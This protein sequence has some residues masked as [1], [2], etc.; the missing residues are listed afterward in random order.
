[1][2]TFKVSNMNKLK[3]FASK[4]YGKFLLLVLVFA[5]ILSSVSGI[6]FMT[7][8]YN[9]L[10]VDDKKVNINEYVNVLNYEMQMAY[11]STKNEEALK[12]IST[13]DFKIDVLNKMLAD[14]VINKNIVD[15][16]ITPN[17]DIILAK[18]VNDPI[19][20]T[21][22]R[23]DIK[24]FNNLIA[25]YGMKDKD[26]IN[27]LK[28][29]ESA[30]ML[31]SLFNNKLNLDLLLEKIYNYYNTYKDVTLFKIAKNKLKIDKNINFNDTELKDYY[32]A[33]I[34]DFIVP[35]TKKID[36]VV[37]PK[38]I[39]K[40]H[41]EELLLT[42]L[43]INELAK[44]LDVKVETMNYID[45][46]NIQDKS[47]WNYN[48]N[49]MSNLKLKDDKYY[50]YSIT[51]VKPEKVKTFEESKDEIRDILYQNALENEYKNIVKDLTNN[52]FSARKNGFITEN[53]RVDRNYDKY[54]KD[55]T[56][57][58]L[59]NQKSDIF[60]DNDFVFFAITNK[61]GIVENPISLDNIK[62][63]IAKT[64]E[65]DYLNYL[66][67]KKYKTKVNYNLLNL[68]KNG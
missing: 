3:S 30:V 53:I 50:I 57:N 67:N 17:N 64:V 54:G 14:T 48:L 45:E 24:K 12:Y 59:N 66:I 32:N 55:F 47:I 52:T 34:N 1:M 23:F 35:E 40:E 36:Y 25:A 21:N 51:D 31:S 60:M 5:F 49:D 16:K 18:I 43:D 41:I 2:I 61:S 44:N 65:K 22:D 56:N 46:N 37:L 42:S 15:L 39:D 19:F 33:N 26:Y 4:E 11:N 68:I 38:D 6:V 63:S 28:D 13:N 9:I 8:K 27:L 29:Q 10:V 62:I 7:N 20:K 58:I